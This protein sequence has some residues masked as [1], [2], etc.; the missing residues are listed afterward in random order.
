MRKFWRYWDPQRPEK[1]RQCLNER[2]SQWLRRI[3]D[4]KCE[5]LEKYIFPEG[6]K[7]S[8]LLGCQTIRH[9]DITYEM[10]CS[11]SS[12]FTNF[13]E[14]VNKILDVH[15]GYEIWV[16]SN[17]QWDFTKFPFIVVTYDGRTWLSYVSCETK[18][19]DKVE[20]FGLF[21]DQG[22]IDSK[23]QMTFLY[24]WCRFR[25]M[26]DSEFEEM[27][28]NYREMLMRD[29]MSIFEAEK[30]CSQLEEK[31]EKYKENRDKE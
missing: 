7:T 28:G 11:L 31:W 26:T 8:I 21:L 13:K 19:E 27:V 29:G 17:K 3:C 18:Q 22:K 24:D 12:R 30:Y 14:I 1:Y 5:L 20:A 23:G 25:E 6:Y 4:Y 15:K 10:V 2:Y 9:Y 16:E